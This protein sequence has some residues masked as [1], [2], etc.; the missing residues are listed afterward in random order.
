MIHGMS[1]VQRLVFALVLL[2]AARTAF[3]DEPWA[4]GV[5]ADQQ[6]T[7][8]AL[9]KEGNAFF[10]ENEFKDALE[11]YVQAL[12]IWDHP[13]IRYNA[14]V[15]LINLDRPVEAYEDLEAALRFGEP[16]LGA[17]VYKQGLSYEK[18][19]AGRIAE[20]DVTARSPDATISLDGQP[21]LHGE[22]TAKR[23]VL[24]GDHQVVAEKPGFETETRPVRVNGG[25][26]VTIVIELHPIAAARQLHLRY[27]RWIPWT[28]IGAG[29]AVALAGL[30]LILMSNQAYA[31]YDA[32]VD[33]SCP[34][35]CPPAPLPSS[36]ASD[37]SRGRLDN[38]LAIS[39]FSVGGALVASGFALVVANQPRLVVPDVGGD[40]IGMMISG[41]W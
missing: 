40:H 12:A 34:S 3:A 23:R 36:I 22:G 1:V 14:A 35:G 29:A 11:K 28:V 4:V 41:S 16:P 2:V 38:I 8:L 5:S 18:L 37:R 30:P 24:S 26:H 39:A 19:L 13:A 9:Y 6:K 15:C 31:R 20:V 25:D 27:P 21:L 7:A 10:V 32:G 17:D 33:A